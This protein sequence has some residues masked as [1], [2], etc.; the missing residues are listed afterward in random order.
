MKKMIVTALAASLV[1]SLAG[2][3]SKGAE[4]EKTTAAAGETKEAGAEAAGTEAAG[5]T[6]VMATN[7]EFP[8]YEYREGDNVVGIDVEIGE[9]IAKSMGMELKVE[10]MAFDSIIVAVD[11]GKADVGLAGLTVTEDRL[12][13]VNFSD[14]Y[15]TATQVVIVKEDSPI[16]SPNDLEGKK[17]G[18]Q[19][20]TTG[21]K[22]AGDIKDATVERYNKGFEAVQ[23]MTQGKI[24][25]VIIDREP[26]KVFVEQ[27][28]GI[29]MLD[30]AYTE[31]EYAIAI[32]K[33]NEELL[34]KVNTALADLK[35]SGEL[36]KI[37]DK[38]IKA[39]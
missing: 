23:A 26:A 25:A 38:Y 39:Q 18:V 28:E 24:D 34:K 19:L 21:D 11:A 37:L 8:P 3:G 17:I 32:K 16:T 14:P 36:Q 22:Y 31:E 7:A 10:D 5:G 1:L 2:C 30:E 35:S 9:A 20:G 29:K 33:D 15:T 4:T 12:M 27:N 13:N 6:L